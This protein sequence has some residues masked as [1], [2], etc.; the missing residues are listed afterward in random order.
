MF[1]DLWLW[2]CDMLFIV[3]YFELFFSLSGLW[4]GSARLCSR[5]VRAGPAR[6]LARWA[7]PGLPVRHEAR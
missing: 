5:A 7:M 6:F 4:A 1:L 2:N 3:V